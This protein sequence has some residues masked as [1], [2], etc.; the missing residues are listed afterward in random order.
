MT[1]SRR[2]GHLPAMPGPAAS[3]LS[4]DASRALLAANLSR[5]GKG[6]RAAFREVYLATSAKLFG[7]CLRI[8]GE[9]ELAEEVLQEVYVT[10]WRKADQFD[11][12]RASPITWLA[13]IARNKAIDRLRLRGDAGRRRPIEEAA[14]VADPAEAADAALGRTQDHARLE[15]CLDGLEPK[16]AAAIRT[17]FFD[18]ATYEALAAR[19]GVPLGTMKSW[20]RRSLQRLKACLDG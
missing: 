9:R 12:A 2:S 11:P 6:D 18:G 1:P 15:A 3:T 7:V 10:I 4:P 19:D 8:L 17:A 14:D 20:I 13:A 16:H 5:A